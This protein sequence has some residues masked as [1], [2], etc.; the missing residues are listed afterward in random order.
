ML[1]NEFKLLIDGRLLS[2]SESI[3]VVNPATGAVFAT[4]PRATEMDVEECVVAARAAQP[5]WAAATPDKRQRSLVALADALREQAVAFIDIVVSEQGKPR[6]EAAAELVGAERLLRYFSALDLPVEQITDPNVNIEVD[7][8]PLG[9]VAGIVPWNFP[10]S[11]SVA[12]LA[13]AVVSGNAFIL[14]PAPTTPISSLMLG[15]LAQSIFPSG[16]VN[17]L[18][19]AGDIG[20]LLTSHA[21]IDKVAFTGSTSV[22]KVVMCSAAQNLKR[23]TLELGGN[24]AAI[25]AGTVDVGEVAQKIFA[26]AFVN[27][28]QV[29]TAVKRVYAPVNV[30]DDLVQALVK[31]ANRAVVGSGDHP[32]TQIGPLHNVAQM[33]KA[34]HFLD[35]ARADGVVVAGGNII[36]GPGYFVQP[37]IVRDIYDTSE[38]VSQ[39]QFIPVLPVVAY[40]NLDDVVMT[41]NT[42]P[43]GLG[44]SIWSSDAALAQRTARRIQTGT[45]WINHHRHTG[46]HIP[47]AGARQSGIGTQFAPTGLVEYMQRRV[48]STM[49]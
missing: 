24:D 5:D 44:T 45:V 43:F 48:I 39:E 15:A 13:P 31:L 9:V 38:L 14:K 33:T 42:S 40:R 21:K 49:R 4:V 41:I 36:D 22:G 29:C 11:S 46:P 7:H 16:V 32:S 2:R 34:A 12:K 1:R 47:F 37:T 28:G 35:I 23:L 17:V 20:P 6:N 27:C 19:D 10:L 25:I 8:V 26:S 18:T 3:D 30:Y